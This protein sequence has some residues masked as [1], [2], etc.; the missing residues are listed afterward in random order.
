MA[1]LLYKE[2][3]YNI[4]GSCFTVHRKLGPGFLES[5]YQEALEKQFIKDAIPYEREKILKIQFDGDQL[6]KTFKADYVCYDK[7]IVE[8]K[9]SSFI[10]NDNLD[11]TYNYLRSTEFKL[12]LIVNFGQKSLVYKRILNSY[13]S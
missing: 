1:D 7:I 6:K 13:N 9:A 2:E 3:S 11:Q 12:G 4:I 10:H 5:V 8:L